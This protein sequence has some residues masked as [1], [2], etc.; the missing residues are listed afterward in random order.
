MWY[1]YTTLHYCTPVWFFH[2]FTVFYVHCSIVYFALLCDLYSE[3][4][5]LHQGWLGR[6]CQELWFGSAHHWRWFMTVFW[7]FWI[8]NVLEGTARYAGFTSS[9]CGGL[10]PLAEAFFAFSKAEQN[11]TVVLKF[12]NSFLVFLFMAIRYTQVHF[13]PIPPSSFIWNT[14]LKF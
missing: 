11:N 6:F 10:L 1:L 5:W 14:H 12:D 4:L 7:N 13:P 2:S 3:L 9:S 8:S